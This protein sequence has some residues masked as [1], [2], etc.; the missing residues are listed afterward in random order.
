MEGADERRAGCAE[1]AA[2]QRYRHHASDTSDG[3][4]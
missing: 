4:V 2:E 3:A 1:N